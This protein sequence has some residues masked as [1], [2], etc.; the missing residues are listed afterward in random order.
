MTSGQERPIET[1]IKP[2]V[3]QSISTT[4]YDGY[5]IN[6]DVNTLKILFRNEKDKGKRLEETIGGLKDQIKELGEEKNQL[7]LHYEELIVRMDE[8]KEIDRRAAQIIEEKQ[9]KA[10]ELHGLSE[11]IQKIKESR[12]VSLIQGEQFTNKLVQNSQAQFSSQPAR[13][14]T[15]SGE[16]F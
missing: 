6:C 12:P 11:T 2:Q 7:V 16:Q 1:E 10:S 3:Y 8:L 5:N 15:K 13:V 9:R 4:D 14:F